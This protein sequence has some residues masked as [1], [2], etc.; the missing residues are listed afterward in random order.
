MQ[1]I[2]FPVTSDDGSL[3]PD[4]AL[5]K[6]SSLIFEAGGKVGFDLTGTSKFA[7]QM[8]AAGFSNIQE[9]VYKWPLNS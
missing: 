5:A 2:C 8:A 9:T 7:T 4:T 1:D 3:P 6:W